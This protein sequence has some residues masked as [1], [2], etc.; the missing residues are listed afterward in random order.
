MGEQ[1]AQSRR[2]VGVTQLGH[3]DRAVQL[4]QLHTLVRLE[5]QQVVAVDGLGQTQQALQCDLGCSTRRQIATAH[6]AGHCDACV[7]D[8][9]RELVGDAAVAPAHHRISQSQRW[10]LRQRF[11]GLVHR[12]DE[13][14]GQPGAQRLVARPPASRPPAG[15]RATTTRVRIGEAAIRGADPVL[16]DLTAR[17]RAR[18]QRTGSRE[19]IERPLV[20]G[21]GSALTLD[22]V[23][24]EAE[25]RE[26]VS[27]GRD[28]RLRAALA[29]EVLEPQHDPRTA[30]SRIEP[31]Q[32]RREQGARMGRAGRRGSKT[33]GLD[34]SSRV[35]LPAC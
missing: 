15:Q 19:P 26:I 18:I 1:A 13:L 11:A 23:E 14:I 29:V 6:D 24:L 10:L 12:L 31:A 16:A 7:V 35:H 25:P 27:H 4:R 32:Q 21:A 3:P 30:R 20:V 22:L 17:A 34:H 28:P 33:A 9:A 2:T 5:Q 8:H